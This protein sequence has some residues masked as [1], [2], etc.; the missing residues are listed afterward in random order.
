[1][2][3][4]VM[5]DSD[6]LDLAGVH[7]VP[8]GHVPSDMTDGWDTL[9]LHVQIQILRSIPFCAAK[10]ELKRVARSW[11]C[12]LLQGDLDSAPPCLLLVSSG[13]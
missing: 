3:Q 2:T 9:P 8:E 12:I 7:S 1:M 4:I 6:L 5:L 11:R 13:A 10:L